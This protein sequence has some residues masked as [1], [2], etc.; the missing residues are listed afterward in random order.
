MDKQETMN[1]Y[2][3]TQGYRDDEH[4]VDVVMEADFPAY[5]ERKNE[6]FSNFLKEWMIEK[7]ASNDKSDH[8]RRILSGPKSYHENECFGIE[9]DYLSGPDD[10]IRK[11]RHYI[12]Y[13]YEVHELWGNDLPTS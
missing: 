4:I 10:E 8:I 12:Q 3:V 5:L 1:I 9:V 11:F 7:N 2:T 13:Q 6:G